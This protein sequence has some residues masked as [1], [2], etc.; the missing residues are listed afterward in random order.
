[1]ILTWLLA[2]P[3]AGMLVV[4]LLPR[5]AARPIRLVALLSSGATL[6]VALELLNLFQFGTPG[7][8]FQERLPWIPPLGVFYQLGVDGISLPMVLL[9]ALLGFLACIASFSITE[10]HK[11][12]FALYLLLE[13][14][15]LGTFLALDLFLFYIFWEIVLVPMYFLI[16]IWGG[17][18]REYSAFK[19]FVYTL[20]GS[21]AMLV[22]ILL[23]YFHARTFDMV[24]LAQLGPLFDPKLQQLLFVLFFLGF[25]IKVP[26]FPFHTWLPDAHVDAPTPGSVL[27]AGVLLKMGG[28][29]FFRIS[30]PMFPEAA[31]SFAWAMALLGA[32][33]IVYGAFVAMAQTDFKRLVAY[34]SV[35]HMG[36][37]LLG[38]ASLTLEG[39]NGAMFQ[40]FSHGVITGG[41]FLLVGVLY[42]RAH[43]RE[44]EAFGGLGARMPVYAGL[45]TF[46]SLAS[47]GLPG[48]SGFVA[49]F[50]SL[51]GAFQ[52]QSLQTLTMI[53]V[54]GIVIA[55][56][57]MLKV[58]R[59]VLLGPLNE[60]WKALPDVNA[61]ELFSLA[62]L[63]VVILALGIFPLLLLHAQDGT[64]RAL[65]AH[66]VGR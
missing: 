59:Q 51:V 39:L 50:L 62:P 65:L 16:G 36:F 32:I 55:A 30:Y 23:L 9:T 54:L 34:S 14:G 26:I 43:T 56:A 58:I 33:N 40:M 46:F 66:V 8:Q 44:L 31:L 35:S 49:E 57:Y 25:A 1:M 21:L 61:A 27:L 11:E 10:R 45:L 3:L 18:R 48:L 5:G 2:I 22:G 6:T 41:M 53:S 28:Y 15:M 63:V 4:L 13:V 64:L 24:Q 20:A 29:G 42:D 52:I 37:V 19:F 12:Y 17:G 7:V 38:L 60:R 47:L